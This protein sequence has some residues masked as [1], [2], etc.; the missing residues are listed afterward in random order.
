MWKEGGEGKGRAR[1]KRPRARLGDVETENEFG[2]V[3][4]DTGG[5]QLDAEG[6]KGGF[7]MSMLAI[8]KLRLRWVLCRRQNIRGMS[9]GAILD[10]R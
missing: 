3:W 5:L 4:L 7:A 2:G 9:F 10:Q 8:D 1:E 6:E